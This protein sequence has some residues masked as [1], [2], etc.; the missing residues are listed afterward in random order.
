MSIVE[1]LESWQA[2][3]LPQR[4][5]NHKCTYVDM[6]GDLIFLARRPSGGKMRGVCPWQLNKRRY[7]MSDEIELTAEKSRYWFNAMKNGE[8]VYEQLETYHSLTVEAAQV[9]AEGGEDPYLPLN[10]SGLTEISKDCLEAL[11][12]SEAESIFLSGIKDFTVAQAQLL[13]RMN[14][15]DLYLEGINEFPAEIAKEFLMATKNSDGR[16]PKFLRFPK[17]L[18]FDDEE[19]WGGLHLLMPEYSIVDYGNGYSAI[20]E[21]RGEE[22]D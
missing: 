3:I 17:D 7:E 19:A 10:L 18:D 13:A 4:E 6:R 16:F 9:L 2:F 11:L 20:F 12:V 15:D 5:M 21:N 8:D 14:V 22:D 1:K